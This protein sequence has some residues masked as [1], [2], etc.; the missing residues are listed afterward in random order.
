MY[1]DYL[2]CWRKESFTS[3]ADGGRT[4]QEVVWM[5]YEYHVQMS[6]GEWEVD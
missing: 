5:N 1:N 3:H 2:R 6:I 4:R